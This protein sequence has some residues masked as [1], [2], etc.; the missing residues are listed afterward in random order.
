MVIGDL[1]GLYDFIFLVGGSLFFFVFIGFKVKSWIFKMG[2]RGSLF[3]WMG[4]F[5]L[6]CFLS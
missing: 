3:G 6:F 5:V 1:N 4:V 2:S